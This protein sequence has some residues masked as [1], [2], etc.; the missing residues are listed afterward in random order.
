MQASCRSRPVAKSYLLMF[1]WHSLLNCKAL[2]SQVCMDTLPSGVGVLAGGVY[3]TLVRRQMFSG[4]PEGSRPDSNGQGSET[5]Q[6]MVRDA[7]SKS[8]ATIAQE[9]GL[10]LGPDMTRQVTHPRAVLQTL[11]AAGLAPVATTGIC[12]PGCQ[13]TS[14]F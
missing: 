1:A 9:R 12:S 10:R 8:L 3:A 4:V 5:L 7:S 6:G 13:L 2:I 11:P 14:G